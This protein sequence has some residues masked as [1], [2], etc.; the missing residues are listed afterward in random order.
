MIY[1]LLNKW[2]GWDYISWTNS[3]DQGIARVHR[4]GNGQAYFWRYKGTHLAARIH[5]ADQ[6]IW[7]TCSPEEYGL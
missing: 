6:V 2:F 4:S 1:K 3:A 5:K 7:L